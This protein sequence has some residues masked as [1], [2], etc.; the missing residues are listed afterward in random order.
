MGI[1]FLVMLLFAVI[2]L[3]SDF[4]YERFSEGIS[5]WLIG[6]IITIPVLSMLFYRLLK[7]PTLAGRH[8]LDQIEG[9]KHYLEVAED[10]GITL[11]NAPRFTTDIYE[12]YLPY[13]IALD[14]ENQWTAKLDHAIESGTV[15]R[16]YSHPRW[17]RSHGYH[18]KSF[19]RALS[20]SFNSAIASSSV[21]PGSSSGSSGGSSGGGGGGGGGGGW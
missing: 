15:E 10:D 1:N 3:S 5:W 13:A 11:K 20:G 17:Y 16:S 19:S 12:T 14:L 8:L 7:A 21:A 9:F 18:D 2:F 4:N 6:G